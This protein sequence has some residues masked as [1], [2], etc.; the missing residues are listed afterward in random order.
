[1]TIVLQL[2][3]KNRQNNEGTKIAPKCM[4]QGDSMVLLLQSSKLASVQFF[5]KIIL[6]KFIRPLS[7][8]C[9]MVTFAG[10]TKELYGQTPAAPQSGNQNSCPPWNEIGSITEQLGKLQEGLNNSKSPEKETIEI[11]I[12]AFKNLLDSCSGNNAQKQQDK[13]DQECRDFKKKLE[14]ARASLVKACK[15]HRLGE[16]GG[17]G[18]KAGE[19]VC[20]EKAL[21]CAD[22]DSE[23]SMVDPILS[24]ITSSTGVSLPMDSYNSR[25]NYLTKSEK[26]TKEKEEDRLKEK[27]ASI[28]NKIIDIQEDGEKLKKDLDRAL[29]DFDKRAREEDLALKERE[30]QEQAEQQQNEVKLKAALRDLQRARLAIQSTIASTLNERA[31]TLAQ[32]SNAIL[33]KNCEQSLENSRKTTSQRSRSANSIIKK[34][35]SELRSYQEMLKNCWLDSLK[36]REAKR[37]EFQSK[38]QDFEHQLVAKQTEEKELNQTLSLI[39]TQKAQVALERSQEKSQKDLERASEKTRIQNERLMAEAVT[40]AKVDEKSRELKEIKQ[41]LTKLSNELATAGI[42]GNDET[43]LEDALEQAQKVDSLADEVASK[44]SDSNSNSS[45]SSSQKK[46]GGAP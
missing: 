44:C 27:I 35:S 16:A 10:S 45:P 42:K 1:M 24:T 14:E 37:I 18:S 34:S 12:N 2:E 7:L 15:N 29:A 4:G 38:I 46:S 28:N 41:K 26:D 33:Q 36:Q 20:V 8:F 32:L 19:S 21:E 25:C 6:K 9:F 13:Q 17:V 40:K 23:E 5:N 11:K 3:S 22:I 43:S 30:R 31:R 39:V